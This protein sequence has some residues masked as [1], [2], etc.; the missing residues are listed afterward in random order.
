MPQHLQSIVSS[1]SLHLSCLFQNPDNDNLID[2]RVRVCGC[3]CGGLASTFP[4]TSS[5][6]V[7]DSC[8]IEPATCDIEDDTYE[9]VDTVFVE[10]E[11]KV[12]IEPVD[13]VQIEPVEDGAVG[14]VDKDVADVDVDAGV[15]LD[16]FFDFFFFALFSS[17]AATSPRLL[18]VSDGRP[19]PP[20]LSHN[21]PNMLCVLTGG[22]A[23]ATARDD[24]CLGP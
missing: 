18:P 12:L 9:D 8:G 16:D 14:A 15:R 1:K 6:A 21:A 23:A 24:I 17:R 19:S 4:V 2:L 11:D 20:T 22:R 5:S 13:K 10:P 3:A 7:V